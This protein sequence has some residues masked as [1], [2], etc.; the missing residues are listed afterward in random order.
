MVH[1]RLPGE[2]LR[3]VLLAAVPLFLAGCGG[4]SDQP[5]GAVT[6]DAASPTDQ[7]SIQLTAEQVQALEAAC[8][9]GAGVPGVSDCPEAVKRVISEEGARQGNG[10]R[11]QDSCTDQSYGCMTL[12]AVDT[13][14]TQEASSTNSDTASFRFT[15]ATFSC[16]SCGQIPLPP[17]T[18]IILNSPLRKLADS[19]SPSSTSTTTEP[20]S[21]TTEPTPETTEPTPA[22]TESPPTQSSPG[23]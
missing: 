8:R 11:P 4:G 1:L 14:S 12:T 7:V 20:T 10:D 9:R 2:R 22:T 13:P 17:A 18:G 16:K 3:V 15:R 19:Q 23:T 5:L 21:T 6:R